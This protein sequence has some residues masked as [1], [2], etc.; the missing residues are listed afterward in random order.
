MQD[1]RRIYPR[2]GWLNPYSAFKRGSKMF[3]QNYLQLQ[4]CSIMQVSSLHQEITQ[5]ESNDTPNRRFVEIE[6]ENS[7]TGL[8]RGL[9]I[10][11]NFSHL[12]LCTRSVTYVEGSRR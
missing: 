5:I 8:P 9:L 6:S 2:K 11:E 7:P 3:Y 4:D 10:T 12:K 1:Q